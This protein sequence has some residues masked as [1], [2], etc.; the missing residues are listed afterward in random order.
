MDEFDRLRQE[1]RDARG[2]REQAQS[3][4]ASLRQTLKRLANRQSELD[5]V[6]DPRNQR[7]VAERSRLAGERRRAEEELERQRVLASD[8][9]GNEAIAIRD[10]VR[11]TDPRQAIERFN[12]ATPILLM[13]IRLETRFKT[14]TPDAGAAAV[15]QLWVR[16]FPDDCWVDSFDPTLTD[17]EVANAKA[18]WSAL[19]MA[20]GVEE[21]ERA[22]WRSL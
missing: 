18:Y 21:Q 9:V 20:G 12:D 4:A 7:H 19:W 11:F 3:V 22:A 2:G 15:P 16:V 17:S 14:S 8:A 5:R 1:L 13:P 6:F 10:F